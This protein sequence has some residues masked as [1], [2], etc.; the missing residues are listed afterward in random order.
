MRGPHVF[1]GYYRDEDATART[2]DA[3]GWLHSGDLGAI[4]ANGFLTITGRRKDL[5]ITSGG[6]NIAPQ[7]IEQALK[8]IPPI[9][10][11]VVSATA[12]HLIAL[13]TLDPRR[14]RRRERDRQPGQTRAPRP[15]ARSSGHI[16]RTDRVPESRFARSRCRTVRDPS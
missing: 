4:D 8:A 3:E 11:A 6:H 10:Q 9:A 1:R 14:S 2:I 7:N 5:I 15:P 16:W 12:E 13:L